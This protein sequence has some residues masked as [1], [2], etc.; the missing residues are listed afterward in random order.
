MA[1]GLSNA[2]IGKRGYL[3]EATVKTHVTAILAN[4]SSATAS[5]P[6]A[7][8]QS[9]AVGPPTQRLSPA[10]PPEWVD[11]M[12]GQWPES[13]QG[14]RIGCPVW[15]LCHCGGHGQET[16]EDAGRGRRGV[17]PPWRFELE[18]ALEG[19]EDRSHGRPQGFTQPGDQHLEVQ[20]RSAAKCGSARRA[21]GSST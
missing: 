17:R 15:S 18:P 2:L 3:S 21:P 19:V 14:R 12:P 5:Q 10:A 20:L 1:R 6:P 9:G 13:G 4:L 11:S 7:P 8:Y 16:L